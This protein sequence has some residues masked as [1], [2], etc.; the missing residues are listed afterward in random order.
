MHKSDVLMH[1]D[2]CM[3]SWMSIVD[4]D[5]TSMK[6]NEERDLLSTH[7]HRLD[8]T[9]LL[10]APTARLY[11]IRIVRLQN[12]TKDRNLRHVQDLADINATSENSP[13]WKWLTECQ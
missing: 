3:Q 6:R 8:G 7:V 11:A 9:K 4:H 13:I 1:C 12:P 5:A 2:N 10:V